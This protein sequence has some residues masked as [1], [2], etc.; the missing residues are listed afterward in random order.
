MLGCF[1][2]ELERLKGGEFTGVAHEFRFSGVDPDVL[3]DELK[4][5]IADN[6]GAKAFE[7]KFVEIKTLLAQ[8]YDS[9]TGT[10]D[11]IVDQVDQMHVM[12]EEVQTFV[13]RSHFWIVMSSVVSIIV[14]IFISFLA[15][16]RLVTQVDRQSTIAR[17]AAEQARPTAEVMASLDSASAEV[18]EVVSLIRG[19]TERSPC[20]TTKPPVKGGGGRL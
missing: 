17:D 5:L 14:A 16:R 8:A 18:G 19:I 4:Q 11:A 9:A 12:D 20:C 13:D 1:L 7:K 6:T 3:Q 15:S 2:S 10:R